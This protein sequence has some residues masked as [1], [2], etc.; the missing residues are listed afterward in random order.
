MLARLQN[1]FSPP[2]FV[3]SEKM[4][5]GRM[6][7]W[8]AI[9]MLV[10]SILIIVLFLLLVPVIAYRTWFVVPLVLVILLSLWATLTISAA[11]AGGLLTPPFHLYVAVVFIAALLLGWRAALAFI[12]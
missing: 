4:R 6:A 1:Y 10:I 3:D 9:A 5:L 2:I 8:I 12:A 7:Y 11:T